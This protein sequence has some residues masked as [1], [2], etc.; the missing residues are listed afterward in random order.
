[1]LYRLSFFAVLL[2]AII[3][4]SSMSFSRDHSKL[5]IVGDQSKPFEFTKDGK[6]VGFDIDLTK[7]ILDKL[8][9]PFEVQL[10]PW[11]RAWHMIET[12]KADASLTTSRKDK[13]KPYVW[14]PD[15]NMW[16]SE[17]VYFVRKGEKGEFK[18]YQT[19][20]G[21]SVGII[22][23]YSYSKEF[24]AAKLKTEAVTTLSQNFKELKA[25]RLDFVITDKVVGSFTAKEMGMLEAFDIYQTPLFSKGYPMAFSKKSGYPG[26]ED[27]MKKFFSE[28][29]TMKKNGQ[30][31]KML[32]KWIK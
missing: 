11:K 18:G 30:Y 32:D 6:A 27:L 1:M 23:G 20:A 14:Y 28:L 16:V 25:G 31:Q 2:G 26:L 17:Y 4:V 3:L 13:R 22:S 24:W 5:L 7:A 10:V 15:T 29:E 12:G 21:K 8:G 19:A 9:V